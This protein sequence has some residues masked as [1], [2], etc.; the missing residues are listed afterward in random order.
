MELLAF[1]WRVWGGRT[2]GCV[3]FNSRL[4]RKGTVRNHMVECVAEVAD[5]AAPPSRA[6]K[7][8]QNKHT[9]SSP[10]RSWLVGLWALRVY[11]T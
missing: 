3:G 1:F 11:P 5:G 8:E 10:V 2:T 4:K 7:E 6:A 9:H